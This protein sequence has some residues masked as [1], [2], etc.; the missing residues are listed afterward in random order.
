MNS[1]GWRG[2]DFSCL[3]QGAVVGSY[4]VVTSSFTF[5]SLGIFKLSICGLI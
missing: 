3:E 2:M 4:F 5:I 1:V